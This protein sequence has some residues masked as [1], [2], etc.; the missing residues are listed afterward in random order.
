MLGRVEKS[1]VLPA[2]LQVPLVEALVVVV[3]L[4]LQEGPLEAAV[5]LVS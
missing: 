3:A 2:R 5:M 4:K 1:V